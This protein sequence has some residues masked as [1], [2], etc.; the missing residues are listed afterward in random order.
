[1]RGWSGCA[2]LWA[3]RA[4]PEALEAGLD[5]PGQPGLLS[6]RRLVALPVMGVGA[7]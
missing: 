6:G 2:E 3:P 1:M 4:A 7:S 5:G